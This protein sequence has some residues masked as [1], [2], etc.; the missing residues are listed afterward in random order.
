MT[1]ELDCV[2]T[3]LQHLD[4]PK[5]YRAEI[6]HGEIVLSPTRAFHMNT[7]IE[8]V[9]QM[10][11]QLPTDM[12]Y[13]GDTITPFPNEDSELCPD[14]IVLPK[15]EVDKNGSVYP[16]ELLEIAFEVVSPT[17]RSRDYEMKP[18]AYARAGIPVYVIAD[19][20]EAQLVVHWD[21]RGSEY[22]N[23]RTFRY[24]DTA[25]IP[26]SVPLTIDTSALPADPR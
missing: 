19:P 14:I 10:R 1:I 20:Y 12:W 21:P 5:G 8:L 16:A 18:A 11:P 3:T 24:G 22:G 23:R 25:E 6:V 7:I 17:S 13:T 26:G 2:H 15:V 4:V 9:L